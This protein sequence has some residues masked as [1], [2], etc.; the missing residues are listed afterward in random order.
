MN[1]QWMDELSRHTITEIRFLEARGRYPRLHGKNAVRGYHG[2]GGS[3]RLAQL[4]TDQGASG[5]GM[6]RLGLAQA[7]T[8]QELLRGRRVSEV[9]DPEQG[10]RDSRLAAYDFALHDLAGVILNLPVARM[11]NPGVP[12][13]ARVYDGAIYMNDIIPENRPQGMEA[14][15]RDCAQDWALG[16]RMFK[17]KIGRGRRWMEHDEGMAR[18]VELMR[19]IHEQHPGAALM[20]DANDGFSVEDAIEFMRRIEGIPLYWFEEPFRE[21]R[22]NDAALRAYLDRERPG[23]LIAD[24]ESDPDIPQLMDLAEDRLVDVLQPDVCGFGFTA[25]RGWL[26]QLVKR[27]F[28]ASPH[29]WGDVVKTYY[30]AHLAAAYPHH[31]P[32]VEAVLGSVE[33][34]DDSGYT[35]SESM[36]TL[37]DKPGFGMELVWA[38]EIV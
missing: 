5:W 35:L 6:L 1:T 29:A 9:F 21:N 25:W 14:V 28:R 16:H 11:I 34:V 38:P 37:P 4:H 22:E 18:D 30:C 15:L 2:F 36:L 17:V 3:I 7:K 33:G 32:C 12:L 10:V 31:I 19:R 23:T 20:V 13:L 8:A 24:G 27:G 26:P